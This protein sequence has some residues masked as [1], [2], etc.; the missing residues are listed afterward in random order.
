MLILGEGLAAGLGPQGAPSLRAGVDLGFPVSVSGHS[1]SQGWRGVGQVG[2]APPE[3]SE[4]SERLGWGRKGGSGAWK[5]EVEAELRKGERG[6]PG[7]SG[8]HWGGCRIWKETSLLG[9]TV[10]WQLSA[11]WEEMGW[12]Q[13]P[14]GNSCMEVC[15]CWRQPSD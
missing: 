6:W 4:G 12:D 7:R 3:E 2:G 11:R 14:H 15:E 10:S 9:A 8:G 13:D 5:G 1:T